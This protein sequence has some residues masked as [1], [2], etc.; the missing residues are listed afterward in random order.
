[1][2]Q[3]TTTAHRDSAGLKVGEIIEVR[4]REEIL[5]SLDER[6]ELGAL[7]FMP[8][9]LQF[10]GRR[11]RVDKLAI[12]VCDTIDW[13]GMYKMDD[14]VHLAGVRCDGSAHGGCQ[15]GCLL[16]WKETWLKRVDALDPDVDE[17]TGGITEDELRAATRRPDAAGDEV[18]SCQAT[19]LMRAAPTFLP[20]WDVRQ[21]VR[22][23]RSGNAGAWATV[24]S[25][26]VGAFN[27]YQD[28]SKRVLPRVLR[29]RGGLRFPFIQGRL[30]RTPTGALDLQPGELVRVKSV[31]EIVGTLDAENKNRGMS[32]DREMLKYC[33]REARVLRRVE[34]IIDEKTGR[35]IDLRNPCIVLDDVVCTSDYHRRCPRAVYAYWREIWLERV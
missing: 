21:Y 7:P 33:G 18:F 3:S 32:F 24:C 6:G 16:Y 22:D 27:K 25:V 17:L 12:K 11:F 28:L 9:M 8:E 10:C 14:A 5:A 29:I 20:F 26:A 34:R 31:E 15:A 35:M 1:M 23:V 2:Q 13:S 30:R 4:S 19:E